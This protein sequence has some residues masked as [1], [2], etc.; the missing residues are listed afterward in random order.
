MCHN[1]KNMLKIKSILERMQNHPKEII[2]MRFQFAK[3]IFW[4]VAFL[5]FFAYLMNVGGFYTSFLSLDTLAIAVY[6]LYSIL[7][8]VTFWFLYS[9]FE[10]ILLSKNPNSKVIYR[11]IFGV[12]CFLMAIPPILIHTGIISFS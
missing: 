12:I 7:I 5:Y 10:Y 2:E 9:C 11:I 8:V 3:H 1:I 4:L 6:H